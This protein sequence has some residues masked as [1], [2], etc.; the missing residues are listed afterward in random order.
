MANP[1]K[2]FYQGSEYDFVVFVEDKE[3]L[4][5][6]RNNDNTIPLVDIVSIFKVF[7]NRQGGVEGVL[8]EASHLELQ[9]EFG[10]KN[11]DEVII[12]ILKEGQDKANVS[13]HKGHNSTNDSKGAEAI[14]NYNIN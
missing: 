12:K 3:L 1:H 4:D 7:I 5:K 6:Y 8:D 9:N 2:L 11:A 10:T 14:A 13:I